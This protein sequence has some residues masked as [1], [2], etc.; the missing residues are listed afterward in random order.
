MQE[1]EPGDT[2]GGPR[3]RQEGKAA[4]PSEAQ[5]NAVEVP[6]PLCPSFNGASDWAS[7]AL[8]NEDWLH[9]GRLD[10]PGP[11]RPSL[12]AGG[13]WLEFPLCVVISFSFKAFPGI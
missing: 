3:P 12:G 10:K 5:E 7:P 1:G 2:G 9:S 8:F 13:R 4:S 11:G 6:S